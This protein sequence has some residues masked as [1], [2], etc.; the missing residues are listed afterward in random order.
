[1]RNP[2]RYTLQELIGWE[3][4]ERLC[5]SFLFAKG[6]KD[7][8]FAGKVKD[9]GRDAV[10]LHGKNERIIF[11]ISK[12]KDPLLDNRATRKKP[13]KFWREY[14]KWQGSKRT[15]KFVFVSSESLG[16]QKIDLMK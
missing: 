4:F 11:Q 14:T 16:S 8:Q 5:C 2:T 1:M 3:E 9:G 13:S 15:K 7:I 12:E 6:H 10:V